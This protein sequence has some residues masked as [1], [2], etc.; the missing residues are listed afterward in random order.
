MPTTDT[1]EKIGVREALLE[2]RSLV[3]KGWVQGKYATNQNGWKVGVTESDATN[4]CMLGSLERVLEN[5]YIESTMNP[6]DCLWQGVMKLY[7]SE[8]AQIIENT[9]MPSAWLDEFNDANTTTKEQILNVF[10]AAI[11]RYDEF[12]APSDKMAGV[13]N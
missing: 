13:A 8:M 4:F 1:S 11:K 12:G 10:D 3:E 9:N 7:P 6:Y 2:A 5:R